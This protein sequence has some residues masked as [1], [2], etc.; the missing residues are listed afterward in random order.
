MLQAEQ[1]RDEKRQRANRGLS[2]TGSSLQVYVSV[3]CS[4]KCTY[5]RTAQRDVCAMVYW[6]SSTIL[7]SSAMQVT[8]FATPACVGSSFVPHWLSVTKWL[9]CG[10]HGKVTV[11]KTYKRWYSV[12][13]STGDTCSCSHHSSTNTFSAD[14]ALTLG[15]VKTRICLVHIE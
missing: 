14:A 7:S 13:L 4:L 2:R 3:H 5:L 10:V 11:A 6:R 8:S 12:P 9:G 15:V 1:G